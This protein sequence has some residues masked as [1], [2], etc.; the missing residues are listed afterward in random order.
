M[1]Q[2]METRYIFSGVESV[3]PLSQ[4]E[5]HRLLERWSSCLLQVLLARRTLVL[6]KKHWCLVKGSVSGT[7]VG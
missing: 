5:D 6:K 1:L 2:A 4:V 3:A 7:D